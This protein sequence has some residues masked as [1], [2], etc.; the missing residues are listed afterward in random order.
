MKKLFLPL[1]AVVCLFTGC[2][3][4]STAN[5]KANVEP[6]AKD[7]KY[8]MYPEM[9]LNLEELAVI[10]KK[11]AAALSASRLEVV[12]D[13]DSLSE[14]QKK[15]LLGYNYDV[16]YNG[17]STKLHFDLIDFNTGK[18]IA[19]YNCRDFDN[20]NDLSYERCVDWLCKSIKEAFGR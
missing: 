1:L 7:Y 10:Q 2:L 14:D 16:N 18:T 6:N 13:V 4:L 15:S 5:Y 3:S 12:K 11:I 8:V 17:T 20:S 19:S 9:D